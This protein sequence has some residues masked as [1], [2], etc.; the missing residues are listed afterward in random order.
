M[1]RFFTLNTF[2]FILICC[3]YCQSS[4][5]FYTKTIKNS[6]FYNDRVANIDNYI[7]NNEIPLD[8]VFATQNGMFDIV[9]FERYIYGESI[10]GDYCFFHEA[11]ISKVCDGII[12]ESYFVSYNWKEPP[13]STPI[14]V[15]RENIPI[16]RIMNVNDF[17]FTLLNESGSDLIGYDVR[18][19]IPENVDF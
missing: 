8:S 6:D 3:A 9:F 10:L 14:Q 16:E 12:I 2:I 19:Y 7:S 5:F 15:S 13:M 4:D 18:I 11:I 1:R 17:N